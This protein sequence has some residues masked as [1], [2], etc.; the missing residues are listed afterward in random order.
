MLEIVGTMSNIETKFSLFRFKVKE[1]CIYELALSI[2]VEEGASQISK[3][4]EIFYYKGSKVE[5]CNT[6]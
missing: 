5:L 3:I 2:P 6:F 4:V 1:I